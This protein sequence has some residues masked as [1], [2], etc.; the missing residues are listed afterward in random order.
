MLVA[1]DV[2]GAEYAGLGLKQID[3]DR[4]DSLDHPGDAFAY[5]IFTQ[6]ARAVRDDQGVGELEPARLVASGQSQ[7]AAAMVSYINGVQPLTQ[8]FDGFFLHSRGGA[9]LPFP[10][11]G[12]S[13]DL[14]STFGRAATILRADTTAPIVDVQAENDLFGVL[15][16]RTGASARQR[17]VPAVGG[18]RHRPR[19]SH[20]RGRHDRRPRRLRCAD[21]R[22]ADA[23]GGQGRP[24]PPDRLGARGRAAS[25]SCSAGGDRRYARPTS[26]ETPT[27]SPRVVSACRRSTCPPR[28]SAARRG[29]ATT[30]ICI[31]SGSTTPLPAARLAELYASADAVR[32][33][34]QRCGRR[35]HRGRL[36]ARGRPGLD[37]GL[38]QARP[39]RAVARVGEMTH[40]RRSP[41]MAR[42][43]DAGDRRQGACWRPCRPSP[44]SKP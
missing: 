7:S 38:R 24:A 27:A 32:A 39:R 8:A 37:R 42:S 28:C 10:P 21:Q 44:S 22:R 18:R 29:P 33:G 12:E 41:G 15:R 4:Y 1:V 5:D 14:T 20:A 3:P 11:V 40:R 6:V 17:H 19:G 2:P 9:S 23:R 43:P 36:R 31:L 13:V 25:G 30:S 34:L 16:I 35:G 26:S